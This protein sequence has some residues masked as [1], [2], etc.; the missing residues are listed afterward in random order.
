M[1]IT[2]ISLDPQNMWTDSL[3]NLY[4]SSSGRDYQLKFNPDTHTWEHLYFE[5]EASQNVYG[6]RI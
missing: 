2:G 4:Q 3:G 1:N 5:D 6:N